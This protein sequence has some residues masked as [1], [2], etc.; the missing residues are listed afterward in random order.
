MV[1]L[2]NTLIPRLGSCR[3]FEAALKLIRSST[4]WTPLK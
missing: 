4:R 1:C 3:D 2:D